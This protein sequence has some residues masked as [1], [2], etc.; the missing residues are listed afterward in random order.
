MVGDV[1]S[2]L[3]SMSGSMR[4]LNR[5]GRYSLNAP[6]RPSAVIAEELPFTIEIRPLSLLVASDF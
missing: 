3:S 6:G 4:Y 1:H 2:W 5:E